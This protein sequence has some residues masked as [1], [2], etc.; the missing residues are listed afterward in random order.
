[1]DDL[2]RQNELIT[3]QRKEFKNQCK[4]RLEEMKRRNE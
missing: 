2:I 3:T 1:M 4:I